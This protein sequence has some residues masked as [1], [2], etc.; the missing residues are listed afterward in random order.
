MAA[1][2]L[3]CRP[4]Q[5]FVHIQYNSMF[6]FL[7]FLQQSKPQYSPPYNYF[8]IKSTD[9]KIVPADK[10]KRKYVYYQII[11]Y[12]I[13]NNLIVSLWRKQRDAK[14]K[15]GFV[16]RTTGTLY[17]TREDQYLSGAI[18]LQRLWVY[19]DPKLPVSKTALRLS[20]SEGNLT[21]ILFYGY[22]K[23]N[24]QSQL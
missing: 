8:S 3:Y 20:S 19:G 21:H 17:K 13:L 22:C 14:V 4:K 16:R 12:K 24:R 15:V 6:L 18:P 1:I 11:K 5:L 7:V 2:Y 23:R 9:K 10:W